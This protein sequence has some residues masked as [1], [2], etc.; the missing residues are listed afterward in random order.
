MDDSSSDSSAD[1]SIKDP[2]GMAFRL[3]N[4]PT[5][6]RPLESPGDWM[7]ADL[8]M[9]DIHCDSSRL[10]FMSNTLLIALTRLLE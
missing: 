8:S 5:I 9:F 10:N 2:V 6:A 3:G 1:S 4:W 7:V